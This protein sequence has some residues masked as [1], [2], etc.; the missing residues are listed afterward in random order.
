MYE[1][2]AHTI[3]A[4]FC[5]THLLAYWDMPL[6]ATGAQLVSLLFPG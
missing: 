6:Q 4:V 1:V 2:L 3:I 5:Y